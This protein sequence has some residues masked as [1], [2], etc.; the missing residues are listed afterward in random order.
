MQA[1]V[2]ARALRDELHACLLRTAAAHHFTLRP[3][4]SSKI[5]HFPRD[6]SVAGNALSCR[7][8]MQQR[9]RVV[10]PPACGLSAFQRL[11]Q[12]QQLTTNVMAAPGGSQ[13]QARLGPAMQ[14][15]APPAALA[16]VAARCRH[17]QDAD[18]IKLNL[19]GHA[20]C[21]ARALVVRHVL[22]ASAR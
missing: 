14:Q 6:H 17:V 22:G 18:W 21:T 15:R 19:L 7:D 4:Y 9:M 10:R 12:L 8:E 11:H 13:R 20:E 5:E 1:A 3:G 2:R 16:V